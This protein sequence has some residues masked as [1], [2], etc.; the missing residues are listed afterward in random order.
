MHSGTYDTL[1][2][3]A[4]GVASVLVS[5]SVGCTNVGLHNIRGG[6]G[7]RLMKDATEPHGL[8][9]VFI[10]NEDSRNDFML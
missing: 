9:H 2:D 8:Q 3:K 7:R 10:A 4:P 5:P 1:Q 6:S